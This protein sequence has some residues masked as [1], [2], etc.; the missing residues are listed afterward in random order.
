MAQLIHPSN[1]LH[2]SYQQHHASQGNLAIN[3]A[4]LSNQFIQSVSMIKTVV[5]NGG[6][7]IASQFRSQDRR[8]ETLLGPFA[9]EMYSRGTIVVSGAPIVC[10]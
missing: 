5:E 2:D 7:E 8:I 3:Q 1:E 4:N 10:G 6:N 9:D